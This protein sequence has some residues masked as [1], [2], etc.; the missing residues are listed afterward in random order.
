MNDTT[1]ITVVHFYDI[2]NE[3]LELK[4]HHQQVIDGIARKIRYDHGRSKVP[5]IGILKLYDDFATPPRFFLLYIK[6]NASVLNITSTPEHCPKSL[7]LLSAEGK[8]LTQQNL[9]IFFIYYFR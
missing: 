1:Q 2:N 3:T 6:S 7:S 9:D 8:C 4:I 5:M